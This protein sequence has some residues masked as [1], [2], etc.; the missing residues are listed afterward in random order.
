M[1]RATELTMAAFRR[2]I[3]PPAAATLARYGL[4]SEEWLEMLAAQSWMCPICE[5]DAGKLRLNTDHEHVRGFDKLP[6]SEKRQY[7]RGILCAYCNFRRVHSTMS[8]ELFQRCA[9][10]V[11]RYEERRGA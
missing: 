3:T 11:R 7:T 10:Y 9:D 2:G 8:A 4:T 1:T 6:P 5:R